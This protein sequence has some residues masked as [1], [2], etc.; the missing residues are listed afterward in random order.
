MV[1]LSEAKPSKDDPIT[2]TL[3]TEDESRSLKQNRLSFMWY[4]IRGVLTGH[5]EIHERQLCKLRY[6]CPVMRRVDDD[7]YYVHPEF[8]G[9]CRLS[10]DRLP[11]EHQM[12]AMDFVPVTRLMNVKEFAEYLTTIDDESALQGMVLPRPEDLYWA[13]LMKEADRR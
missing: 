11:Y 8:D 4:K 12:A 2:M 10:I 5:G 1:W 3:A 13:A 9:F 6:G 7:G